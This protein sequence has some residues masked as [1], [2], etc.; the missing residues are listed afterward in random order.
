LDT[1]SYHEQLRKAL[2]ADKDH[3]SRSSRDQAPYLQETGCTAE[4][5]LDVVE[6]WHGP[7][8][9]SPTGPNLS[10]DYTAGLVVTFG[11]LEDPNR[12]NDDPQHKRI[13]TENILPAVEGGTGVLLRFYSEHS[14]NWYLG[15]P[16]PN[17]RMHNRWAQNNNKCIESYIRYLIR[18]LSRERATTTRE[19]HALFG[20]SDLKA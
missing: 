1:C 18:R 2:R 17:L 15:W 12:Y 4:E 20:D 10:R 14:R 5:Q 3:A 8:G 11:S 13:L 7:F 9:P 6:T 16:T 19:H